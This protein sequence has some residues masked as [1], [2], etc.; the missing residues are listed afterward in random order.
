MLVAQ[1]GNDLTVPRWTEALTV[2][3]TEPPSAITGLMAQSTGDG[4]LLSW[5]QA[6]DNVEFGAYNVS[7]L[8]LGERRFIGGGADES[9]T[10]FLDTDT[11][12]GT[13]TYVVVAVDFHDNRSTPGTI[14]ITVE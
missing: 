14:E 6:T 4:V 5:D 13:R 7:L 12:P 1:I 9:Q 3:D 2:D 11:S 10:M 8:E